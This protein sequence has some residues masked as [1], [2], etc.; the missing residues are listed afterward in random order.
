MKNDKQL[1]ALARE[2]SK[3]IMSA[4]RNRKSRVPG[5]KTTPAHR[6]WLVSVEYIFSEE[7]QEFVEEKYGWEDYI[8]VIKHVFDRCKKEIFYFWQ[9]ILKNLIILKSKKSEIKER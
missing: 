9:I 4:E 2:I 8:T 7:V 1:N 3:M 6:A 5:R